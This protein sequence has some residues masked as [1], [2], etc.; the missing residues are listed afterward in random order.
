M[1]K[2]REWTRET[3]IY[4]KDQEMTYLML[5]LTSEVGEVADKLKKQIRDRN[6][7]PMTDEQLKALQKEFGD[8]MW[9]MA[10]LHDALNMRFID[11]IAMNIGKLTSRKSNDTLKGSGDER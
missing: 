7:T 8:I 9:Y 10:R 3:A 4:P 1:D 5:G 6:D 2:Y 11:T